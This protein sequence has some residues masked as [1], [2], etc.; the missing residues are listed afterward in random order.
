MS[1]FLLGVISVSVI[2]AVCVFI[3][4]ML[5]LKEAIRSL[6]DMIK[7]T[8]NNLN[9]T[10][11]ELRETLK[12]LRNITDNVTDV[13]EHVK[14]VTVNIKDVSNSIKKVG[15]TLD[16][17]SLPSSLCMSG[18]KAGVIAASGVLLKNLLKNIFRR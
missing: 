15:K 17:M 2:A 13:T 18:I 9:P 16:G 7:T 11:E 8:E 12:S 14:A 10:L 4:V 3:Y 1:N 6:K 5:E